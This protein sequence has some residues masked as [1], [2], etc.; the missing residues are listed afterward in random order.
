MKSK[1]QNAGPALARYR[2]KR[3]FD[4]TP[5]PSGSETTKKDRASRA[6][7]H[8]VVQKHAAKRLHYDFRMEHE[9]VLLSWAV[10]KGPSHDPKVKRLAVETEPHPMGYGSFEG[11]IPKG[12]YG[13]GSVI[14]WDH[15]TYASK[16][17]FSAGYTKGHLSFELH[18]QKLHGAWHLVRTNRPK[19]AWLLFKATDDF[20]KP[21]DT[22]VDDAP[23]SVL[24]GRTV[25]SVERERATRSTTNVR[26]T[27]RNVETKTAATGARRRAEQGESRPAR[28]VDESS[29]GSERTSKHLGSAHA[30]RS[31]NGPHAA[32]DLAKLD[33]AAS[34][35]E[36]SEYLPQLAT[37][38]EHPPEGPE[39]C[40]EIKFDGYRLLARIAENGV[41]LWTRNG[42]NWT[43]KLDTI[44]R[45][46]AAG[47]RKSAWLDGELVALD[48]SG[49][50]NFQ[51]LQNTL[52]GE[53]HTALVYYVFDVLYLDG[54]DL[55]RVTLA[56]RKR[57]LETYL[58]GFENQDVIP[59]ERI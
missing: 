50:S 44:A 23:A 58:L 9:G 27:R 3:H 32:I 42:K 25:E 31:R 4:R 11:T 59:P 21:D 5:E 29:L 22:T 56:N 49:R 30:S 7:P 16:G 51:L 48:A 15:G 8:F 6:P 17:D 57:V 19:D 36:H 1:P 40:H 53:E 13:A 54:Y 46:L 26:K 12:E 43:N 39:W 20:S 35:A 14:V 10:P 33:G 45:A 41:E 37:L 2:S 47:P 34:G 55:R 18:G 28:L 38:V 24:T 52:G